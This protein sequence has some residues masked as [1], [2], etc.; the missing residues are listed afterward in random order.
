MA[1]GTKRKLRYYYKADLTPKIRIANEEF[2][3]FNKIVNK[4]LD[5]GIISKNFFD[6]VLSLKYRITEWKE[7]A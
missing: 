3:F 7:C 4:M 1:S 2:H 5:F 6:E